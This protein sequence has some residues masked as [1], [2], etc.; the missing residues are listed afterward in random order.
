IRL[1][2]PRW[3]LYY[4]GGREIDHTFHYMTL[5]DVE[6][7]QVYGQYGGPQLY[8]GYKEGQ[9]PNSQYDASNL[10][11]LPSALLKMNLASDVE[12]AKDG[13]SSAGR[14]AVIQAGGNVSIV[15]TQELQ[16]SVIHQDYA[17]GA[18]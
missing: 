2:K 10:L 4:R 17:A 16:N 14:S 11:Q 5:T 7:G 15:A 18:T 1:G 12:V 13:S 6:T 8:T 3:E 9:I